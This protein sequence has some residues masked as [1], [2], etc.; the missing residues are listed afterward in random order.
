MLCTVWEG[1][2]GGIMEHVSPL[3]PEKKKKIQSVVVGYAEVQK[4]YSHIRKPILLHL[5][6]RTSTPA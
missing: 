2:G 5:I 1:G 3:T 6:Q 4:F